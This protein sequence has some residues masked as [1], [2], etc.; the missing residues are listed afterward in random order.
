M[1][2]SCS[3]HERFAN[4]SG[5]AKLTPRLVI[6]MLAYLV[7]A[8]LQQI[9]PVQAP[10]EE[11]HRGKSL[12][13]Y[14]CAGQLIADGTGTYACRCMLSNRQHWQLLLRR[15]ISIVISA[16]AERIIGSTQGMH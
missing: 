14:M 7:R 4:W 10:A 16:Q 2:N 9:A 6:R 13:A 11:W 12:P 8:P 15:G 3:A 5:T 1:H